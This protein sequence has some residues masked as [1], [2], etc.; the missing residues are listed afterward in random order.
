MI[1]INRECTDRNVP[2]SLWVGLWVAPLP[3][4]ILTSPAGPLGG[5]K[6][7]TRGSVPPGGGEGHPPQGPFAGAG[8]FT[9]VNV[10]Y[11]SG[12]LV[13]H[14]RGCG[15]PSVLYSCHSVYCVK[16]QVVD[17]WGG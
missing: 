5:V 17:R 8:S 1:H 14:S 16:I 13:M 9:G 12:K 11:R 10:P 15:F 2:E 3:R 7:A 4:H 6:P